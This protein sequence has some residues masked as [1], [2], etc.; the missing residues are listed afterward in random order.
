MYKKGKRHKL[1]KNCHNLLINIL[2]AENWGQF[3]QP[4]GAKRKCHDSHSSVPVGAIQ[5]QQ[6]NYAQLRPNY[7][8][9]E[10]TLNL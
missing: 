4:Y 7:A 1:K 2:K 6:Q 3:H 8:Q 9:L 5:F 10:N